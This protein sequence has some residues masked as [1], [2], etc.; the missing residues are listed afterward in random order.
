MRQCATHRHTPLLYVCPHCG[1]TQEQNP[2]A[3]LPV[4]PRTLDVYCPT[5]AHHG[6]LFSFA[7]AARGERGRR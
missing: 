1:C 5:C 4:L 6:P 2:P 3:V 7:Q